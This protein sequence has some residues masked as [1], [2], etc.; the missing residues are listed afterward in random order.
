MSRPGF[1]L[2]HTEDNSPLNKRADIVI[3]DRTKSKGMILDPT[4][5]LETNEDN[6]D[7]LVNEE[8]KFILPS[9]GQLSLSLKK[10]TI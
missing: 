4:F 2:A 1:E 7:K 6:Q 5:R 3:L 8:N 9:L 10:S